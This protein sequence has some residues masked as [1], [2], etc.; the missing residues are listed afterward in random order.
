MPLCVS[1]C[2][3]QEDEISRSEVPWPSIVSGTEQGKSEYENAVLVG[4][5][6]AGRYEAYVELDVRN[7]VE[8]INEDNNRAFLIF[9]I[10]PGKDSESAFE[11]TVQ[12]KGNASHRRD[13]PVQATGG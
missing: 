3:K 9:N 13:V 1:G 5:L 7:Q 6:S 11:G 12:R 4:P 2:R 8:E 10:R